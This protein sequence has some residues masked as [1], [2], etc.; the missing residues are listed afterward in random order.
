MSEGQRLLD[1][2]EAKDNYLAA[3]AAS[4]PNAAARK[5]NHYKP[6]FLSPG[7][8]HRLRSAV[9]RVELLNGADVIVLHPSADNGFPHTRPDRIVC[10]PASVITSSNSELT[11]TL[12]HEAMHINQRMYPALWKAK[13]KREGWT[14]VSIS[15]IPKAYIERCRINPDTMYDAPFWAWDKYH[16]PLP[17]FEK[18]SLSNDLGDVRI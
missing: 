15:E 11:E 6:Y 10:V 13:C 1:A 2:A 3:C 16:V 4:V 9:F 8:A 14:E 7:D 5:G 12:R 18:N 17:M